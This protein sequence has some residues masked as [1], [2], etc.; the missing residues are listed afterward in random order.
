MILSKRMLGFQGLQVPPIGLGCMGMS[1]SYGSVRRRFFF[2]VYF[3]IVFLPI[4]LY[5]GTSWWEPNDKKTTQFIVEPNSL[6]DPHHHPVDVHK[7]LDLSKKPWFMSLF[8]KKEKSRFI[9][10]TKQT[11][12]T[13]ENI[14][15]TADGKLQAFCTFGNPCRIFVRDFEQKIL[16]EI[17]GLPLENRPFSDL[18]WMKD[19]YLIFDRWSNPHYGMHYVVDV[20]EKKVLLMTSFPDG[21]SMAQGSPEFAVK[22]SFLKA[23]REGNLDGIKNDINNPNLNEATKSLALLFAAQNCNKKIAEVMIGANVDKNL[24][25]EDWGISPLEGAIAKKCTSVVEVMTDSKVD[26]NTAKK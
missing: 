17:T 16:Y 13:P 1:R 11:Q 26:T 5:G 3:L 9:I 22:S 6:E 24:V 21:F 25:I 19:K 18:V 15:T 2:V 14:T 23:A 7:G 8:V 12:A 10:V 4:T 20:K